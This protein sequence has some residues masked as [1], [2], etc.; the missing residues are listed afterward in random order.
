MPSKRSG[1]T[2]QKSGTARSGGRGNTAASLTKVKESAGGNRFKKKKKKKKETEKK[3]DAT[4]T[5]ATRGR[6]TDERVI[7]QRGEAEIIPRGEIVPYVKIGR[8]PGM[9]PADALGH[10]TARVRKNINVDQ[11]LL[12]RARATTGAKSETETVNI[13]L[14]AATRE[15]EFRQ[16]LLEGYEALAISDWFDEVDDEDI[17]SR[18]PRR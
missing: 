15:A 18:A 10:A 12:D 3:Y 11:A 1:S 9:P 13:G 2:V 8:V 7:P 17:P 16:A 6:A 5:P 4:R 14:Q